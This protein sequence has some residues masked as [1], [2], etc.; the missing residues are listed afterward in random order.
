MFNRIS[1]KEFIEFNKTFS[2]M[3]ISKLSLVQALEILSMQMKNEKFREI[4]KKTLKDIKSGLSLSK[5]FSKYPE[6]FSEIYIANL[7]VGEE[8]GQLDTVISEYTEYM[9]TIQSL[10][11]K[12]I[13]AIRYP[14]LVLFVAAGVISFMVFFLIPTFQTLFTSSKFSLPPLT[15][16]IMAVSFLIKDNSPTIFIAIVFLAVLFINYKKIETL[17]SFIELFL[18]KAPLISKIYIKNV[19]AR[20][21]LSLSFLLRSKVPLLEALKISRNT[22]SNKLFKDEIDVIVKK[23]SKGESF[24][25]VIKRSGFFDI[26]FSQLL[27]AGEESA[28]LDKVFSLISSYYQKDFEFFLDNLTS[29]LEPVLILTIGVIVAVILVAMYMPIFEIVN[30]F[31]V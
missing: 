5:S 14:L 9:E 1:N 6:L 22:T 16:T 23:I 20:F 18:V 15:Q 30:N 3:L 21:S 26:T 10:K 12:V 24:S 2:L 27:I 11:R 8:T 4:I 28:Q 31:G 7:R 19:V 13:Q 17:N 25:A 29:L